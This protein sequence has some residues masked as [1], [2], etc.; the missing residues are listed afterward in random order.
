MLISGWI[1]VAVL[2][3][4][5]LW[6]FPTR[7]PFWAAQISVTPLHR[8]CRHALERLR[9]LMWRDRMEL[10]RAGFASRRKAEEART[11]SNRQLVKV[12]V[13][14]L[15]EYHQRGSFPMF[16]I[17]QKRTL[18][19]STSDPTA[20][21][22][23]VPRSFCISPTVVIRIAGHVLKEHRNG[24]AL[25]SAEKTVLHGGIRRRV[26]LAWCKREDN[27]TG[28]RAFPYGTASV[29]QDVQQIRRKVITKSSTPA[30]GLADSHSA[31]SPGPRC[32]A[33]LRRFWRCPPS[34]ILHR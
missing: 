8:T 2:S 10:R 17:G 26:E 28:N 21:F 23:S 4:R 14:D 19:A 15:G 18:A 30:C 7:R 16:A 29:A 33:T 12:V 24:L 3:Y 34:A 5:F 6:A 22:P 20:R 25:A 1:A 9:G 32:L 13:I 27:E 11:V 31:R